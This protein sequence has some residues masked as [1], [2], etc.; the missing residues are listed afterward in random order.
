ML[1]RI[2][3]TQCGK[4]KNSLSPPKYFVKQLSYL[5]TSFIKTLLSRNIGTKECESKFAYFPHCVAWLRNKNYCKG[6]TVIGLQGV[7]SKNYFLGLKNVFSLDDF[8]QKDNSNS[9]LMFEGL[10]LRFYL[11][12]KSWSENRSELLGASSLQLQLIGLIVKGF[13][14]GLPTFPYKCT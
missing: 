6:A 3:S 9:F 7:F 14:T 1:R 13:F 2:A 12:C 4:T 11:I 5:V 8:W 10:F